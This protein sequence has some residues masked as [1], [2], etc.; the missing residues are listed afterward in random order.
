MHPGMLFPL[1]LITTCFVASGVAANMADPPVKVFSM[2]ILQAS[3]VQFS[4][5][6]ACSCLSAFSGGGLAS[7]NKSG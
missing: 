7:V 1:I 3:F 6:R 5:D 2:S 4:C